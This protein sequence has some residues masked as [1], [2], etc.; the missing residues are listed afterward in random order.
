MEQVLHYPRLD[1]VLMVEDELKKAELAISKSALSRKLPKQIMRQTLNVILDYL[2]GK[3]AIMI[4]EKGVLW[5]HDK[6]PKISGKLGEKMQIGIRRNAL[7][8]YKSEIKA[9]L[10]KHGIAKAGIFGSYARGDQ[11]RDSDIDILVLPK[12]G[13]GFAFFGL[14]IELEEKLGKKVDLVSY[15]GIRKELKK[16]ILKEEVRII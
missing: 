14:Q 5:I 12:K 4:G 8:D 3:G 10:K 7:D 9:I 11:K 13:M 6:S 16:E 15:N 2:E 1:T